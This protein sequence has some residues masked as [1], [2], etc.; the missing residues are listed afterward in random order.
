MDEQNGFGKAHACVDHIYTLC[1][2]VRSRIQDNKPTFACISGFE[3]ASDYVSRDLLAYCELVARENRAFAFC[4]LGEV[5]NE[6]HIISYC[7][8]YDSLREKLF[9]NIFDRTSSCDM[10]ECLYTFLD[11][12]ISLYTIDST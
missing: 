9:S 11:C 5:E 7:P 4:D 3:K 2:L 10:F 1:S 8:L 6:N 12:V